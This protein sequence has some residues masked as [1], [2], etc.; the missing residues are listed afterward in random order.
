MASTPHNNLARSEAKLRQHYTVR[1]IAALLCIAATIL[2][3]AF[4]LNKIL[5]IN[6]RQAEIINIA[7]AQRMLSQR[8]A[9]LT[10]RVIE[11]ETQAQR[12]RACEDLEIALERMEAGHRFLTTPGPD[13]NVPALATA[14][15]RAHYNTG[16]PGADAMVRGFLQSFRAFADNP[17]I[18][19]PYIEHHRL[20]AETSMLQELDLAVDLYAQAATESILRAI[21]IHGAW[22]AAALFMLV[23]E[24]IVIFRPMARNAA[25]MVAKISSEL[26]ERT[27]TLSRSMQI[28]KM[29]LWRATNEAADPL[30]ISRELA[31]LYGLKV[32]EGLV[33]LWTV[34][35]GDINGSGAVDSDAIR[36]T[37]LKVWHTG[38]PSEARSRFCKPDGTIIDIVTD[39]VAQKDEAGQVIAVEGVV[40]DITDEAETHRLL[41]RSIS[42]NE[43]Q[44]KDLL[45]AQRIGNMANWRRRLDSDVFEWDER[46]FEIMKQ[47]RKTFAPTLANVE[48]LYRGDGLKRVLDAQDK[49]IE[50]G[51]GQI[52]DVQMMRG[53]NVVIDVQVR[54]T[55]EMKE[56]GEPIALFGTIQDITVEKN[57]ERELEKLAYYDGLTGLANRTLFTRELNKACED[58]K[59]GSS[60]SALLL[61][62]LDHFKE[63]NDSLGHAAGD[64][65]LYI[66]ADRLSFQV[67]SEH[68]VGRLGGDE[69]AIILRDQTD[70]KALEELCDAI[71]AR[72]GKSVTLSQGEVQVCAS[73]GLAIAPDDSEDPDELMRFADLALYRSK[74]KGRGRASRF[75]QSMSDDIGQRTALANDVRHALQNGLFEAHFQPLI[76]TADGKVCGFETL[77]RLPHPDRGYIPPSEFIPIAESSHIIAELGAFVL[78]EACR[79]AKSWID[80]GL[81]RRSVAVNVSAAQIWHGD[82]ERIVD[83]ALT[84]SGLDLELLCLELTESVFAAESLP[85]LTEILIRLKERGVCLALDDFG[86]GYSSLS[87]LNQ[88]PFNK[89][90]IDRAFVADVDASESRRKLLQGIVSLGHGLGMEVI[91]EGVE[92][93]R[94]LEVVRQLGCEIVQGWY[95]GKA[96][97]PADAIAEAARIDGLETLAAVRR[98]VLPKSDSAQ[99]NAETA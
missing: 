29:G 8:L 26:E 76:S 74:E 70:N 44:R 90:K 91:A 94:E 89:L 95:F 41:Q 51:T 36:S 65:L 45:E 64:E 62:D 42:T 77:L 20:A 53:D 11:G 1:Y 22:V 15:L 75:D 18:G 14:E 80:A 68:F 98:P 60:P 40:T 34:Q 12:D 97:K 96:E 55:L 83:G 84:S 87:Y 73:I 19:A 86:T 37:F 52:V 24:I 85:K 17:H 7:G 92:T 38:E 32:E 79:E 66:I 28:A 21:R 81:P 16:G 48:N 43:D 93:S 33:P 67:G 30:W 35:R 61:L 23:L 2:I 59:T 50:T 88:L 72:V 13:G 58:A 5:E 31:A 57:A 46:T 56:S 3:G 99:N 9:L 4:Q 71:I 47:S 27:S 82:L 49:A 39:M 6:E 69:F 63:V 10:P 25:F 54:S 78:N